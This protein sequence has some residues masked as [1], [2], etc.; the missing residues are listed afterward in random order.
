MENKGNTIE[1][2]KMK[3]P[4]GARG[5]PLGEGERREREEENG[6]YKQRMREE[7]LQERVRKMHETF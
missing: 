4:S 2:Y 3:E 6:E 7:S 5:E 1:N